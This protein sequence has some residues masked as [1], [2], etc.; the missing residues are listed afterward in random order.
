MSAN[1]KML[2]IAE[3]MFSNIAQI[4]ELLYGGTYLLRR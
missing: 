4:I 2:K 1:E 3:R